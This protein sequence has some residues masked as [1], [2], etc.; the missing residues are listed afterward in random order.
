M[1]PPQGLDF[2]YQINFLIFSLEKHGSQMQKNT[3]MCYN[4]PF[5]GIDFLTL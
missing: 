1:E 4:V 3:A 5:G 2:W